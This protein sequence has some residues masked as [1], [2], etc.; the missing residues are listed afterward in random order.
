MP[1]FAHAL[2][3]T[4]G[5]V[6]IPGSRSPVAS[7]EVCGSCLNPSGR[8]PGGLAGEIRLMMQDRPFF[9]EG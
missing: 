2:V 9:R 8:G 5:E 7:L 1:G 3:F 4:T 6:C